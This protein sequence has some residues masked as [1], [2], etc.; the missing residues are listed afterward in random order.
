M[1]PHTKDFYVKYFEFRPA[2]LHL[3]IQT[4]Q[5]QCMAF[6][7]DQKYGD[8]HH[9]AAEIKTNSLWTHQ[10]KCKDISCGYQGKF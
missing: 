5:L 3:K 1:P 7:L 8:E 9:L 10:E 4:Q 6:E 2:I